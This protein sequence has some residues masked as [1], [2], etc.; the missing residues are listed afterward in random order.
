MTLFNY[1]K[2]INIATHYLVLDK[3]K[4]FLE[5]QGWTIDHYEVNK[6]WADTGGGVYAWVAGTEYFLQVSSAGYGAQNMV[7]RLHAFNQ[8]QVGGSSTT[9]AVIRLTLVDPAATSISPIST[10]PTLQNTFGGTFSREMGIKITDV[11]IVW[12][13]GYEDKF[14]I[15]VIKCSNT[16]YVEFAF[17]S[18]DLVD[19]GET[20]AYFLGKYHDSTTV[21]WDTLSAGAAC[22][23]FGKYQNTLFIENTLKDA[24]FAFFKDSNEGVTTSGW[25]PFNYLQNL[26]PNS[27]TN[28]KPA[29]KQP[30]GYNPTGQTG[31]I[32]LLGTMPVYLIDMS[33]YE[34]GQELVYGS[35]KYLVFPNIYSTRLYGFSVRVQ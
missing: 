6:T 29:F 9:S 30:V 15:A 17:G 33:G 26:Q 19:S 13:L 11:P 1:E 23:P 31:V 8:N 3:I 35:Q 22:M 18:P 14:F 5:S 34:P 2:H 4:L 16:V 10:H 7:Y 20:Q 21:H 24:L 12:L 27:F 32:K 28:I 25:G